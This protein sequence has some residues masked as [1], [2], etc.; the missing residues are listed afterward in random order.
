MNYS[1]IRKILILLSIGIMPIL[2]FIAREGTLQ[3]VVGLLWIVSIAAIIVVYRKTMKKH[4]NDQ[5]EYFDASFRDKDQR[6]P[7]DSIEDEI[8]EKKKLD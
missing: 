5:G 8:D 6:V 3:I 2:Y 7:M 4:S 1:K